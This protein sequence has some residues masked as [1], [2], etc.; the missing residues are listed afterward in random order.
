[1]GKP[2]GYGSPKGCNG[3]MPGLL[4]LYEVVLC[5][6]VDVEVRPD[7]LRV[8][9]VRGLLVVYLWGGLAVCCWRVVVK[10]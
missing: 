5:L 2:L 6:V 7:A 10:T 1:M 4:L 3:G 8:V 9:I